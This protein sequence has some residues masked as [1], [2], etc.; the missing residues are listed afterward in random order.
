ML[1]KT[2]N[3]KRLG[4]L[5]TVD[6]PCADTP[7]PYVVGFIEYQPHSLLFVLHVLCRGF[8]GLNSDRNY[9]MFRFMGL[10]GLLN[11][12]VE[13]YSNVLFLELPEAIIQGH[14]FG[15]IEG[16]SSKHG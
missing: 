14:F 7:W 15:Q 4:W 2:Y 12:D 16:N 8:Y 13:T 5:S 6:R 1:D 11:G 3:R 9:S 10:L